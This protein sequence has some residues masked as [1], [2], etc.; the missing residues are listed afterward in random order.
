MNWRG[1]FF[2]VWIALTVVWLIA[3]C[4]MFYGPISNPGPYLASDNL[5]YDSGA[6]TYRSI[7]P[8]PWELFDSANRLELKGDIEG[9]EWQW[10]ATVYV[11]SVESAL[12]RKQHQQRVATLMNKRFVA[13]SNA[14]RRRE[15]TEAAKVALVPPAIL[16]FAGLGVGWV[17]SGF[18]SRKA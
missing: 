7:E 14:S 12:E 4:W 18:R 13:L 10:F 5:R 6:G 8:K 2:R 9:T 11:A 15:I 3:V 16:L 17:L 1:G